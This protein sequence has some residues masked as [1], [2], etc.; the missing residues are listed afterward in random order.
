MKEQAIARIREHS[1]KHL[2]LH[3]KESK[4]EFTML[5]KFMV[6]NT[7]HLQKY[8]NIEGKKDP[9][10]GCRLLSGWRHLQ[11]F[12]KICRR[13][14]IAKLQSS[15]AFTSFWTLVYPGSF[16]CTITKS[17]DGLQGDHV[18]VLYY[19]SSFRKNFPIASQIFTGHYAKG[20]PKQ[21]S[22]HIRELILTQEFIQSQESRQEQIPL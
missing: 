6:R 13:P 19:S 21:F 2:D 3:H 22:D 14:L 20:A 9:Y 18:I 1:K 8:I 4:N 11:R 12:Y 5:G 17:P 10:P 16:Y 15:R 7:S